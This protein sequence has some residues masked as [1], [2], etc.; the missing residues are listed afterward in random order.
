M[1]ACPCLT[2]QYLSEAPYYNLKASGPLA[3]GHV[4]GQHL[5]GL[6]EDDRPR[7]GDSSKV[8]SATEVK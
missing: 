4:A 1:F 3:D 2:W 8:L 5:D 7:Q 6:N